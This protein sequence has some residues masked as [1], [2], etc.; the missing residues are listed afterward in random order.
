MRQAADFC[1][2]PVVYKTF[3]EL[4]R[5]ESLGEW[6]FSGVLLHLPFVKRA[7]PEKLV[8]QSELICRRLFRW[9]F[10]FAGQPA[11]S[12]IGHSSIRDE[13]NCSA[14]NRGACLHAFLTSCNREIPLLSRQLEPTFPAMQWKV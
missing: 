6:R 2:R 4:R 14:V 13:A 12:L 5:M 8:P 7:I 9:S 10:D 1:P 11:H 3:G